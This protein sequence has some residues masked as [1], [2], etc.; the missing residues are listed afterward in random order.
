MRACSQ[1]A[2]WFTNG[3]D[4]ASGG[5]A[6]EAG[7]SHDDASGLQLSARPHPAPIARRRD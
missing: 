5:R 2:P 4:D 6:N 1:L 7:P 3:D